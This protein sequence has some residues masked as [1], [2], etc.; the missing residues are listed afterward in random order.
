M[1]SVLSAVALMA[2]LM[3]AYPSSA[4]GQEQ[5][6]TDACLE[7]R[8]YERADATMTAGEWL[9]AAKLPKSSSG[10]LKAMLLA[11]NVLFKW[12]GKSHC[13]PERADVNQAMAIAKQFF[14]DHPQI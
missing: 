2:L 4:L 6:T 5:C 1:K 11:G 9:K 10:Y 8:S 12:N 14:Q 13:K 7:Q 3:L